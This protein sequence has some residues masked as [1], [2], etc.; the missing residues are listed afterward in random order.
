MRHL[1]VILA[2]SLLAGG[3]GCGS[4]Q[5]PAPFPRAP[6]NLTPPMAPATFKG[7]AHPYESKDTR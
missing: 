1:V 4:A 5:S 7:V 3:A 6:T 2:L